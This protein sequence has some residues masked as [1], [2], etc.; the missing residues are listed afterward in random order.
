MSLKGF[1]IFFIMVAATFCAAMAGWAFLGS[2]GD[3]LGEGAK[4][5]GFTAIIAGVALYAYGAWF[6]VKKAKHIIV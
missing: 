5:F 1:H 4:P 2:S 3:V 6:A